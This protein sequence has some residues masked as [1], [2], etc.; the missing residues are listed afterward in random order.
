MIT[1]IIHISKLFEQSSHQYVIIMISD[2][3][4]VQSSR[5]KT[6]IIKFK[7]QSSKLN[8]QRI[9]GFNK[10]VVVN[11]SNHKVQSSKFNVQS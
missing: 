8:V 6:Q 3:V 2:V 10:F 7:V 1:A 9:K 11:G 4:T 5:V